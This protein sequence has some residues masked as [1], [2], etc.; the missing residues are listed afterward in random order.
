MNRDRL[1]Q[2]IDIYI[3]KFDM[4]C[5]RPVDEEILARVKVY[6]KL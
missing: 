5:Q 2:L 4:I 3:D 6:G 1:N